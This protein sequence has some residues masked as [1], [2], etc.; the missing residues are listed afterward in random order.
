[1]ILCDVSGLS[2]FGQN[3]VPKIAEQLRTRESRDADRIAIVCPSALM[4]LQISRLIVRPEVCLFETVDAA[5]EWLNGQ[6]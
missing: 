6:T 5:E 4:R 3:V 1:M 2:V